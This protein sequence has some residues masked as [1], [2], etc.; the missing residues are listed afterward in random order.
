M[1][2]IKLPVKLLITFS[3]FLNQ[4]NFSLIREKLKVLIVKNQNSD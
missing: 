1:F 2:S 4:L 3:L